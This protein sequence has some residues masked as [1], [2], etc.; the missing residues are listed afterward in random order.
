M[1]SDHH[2]DAAQVDPDNRLLW[3]MNRR[4]LT[5]ESIRDGMQAISGRLDYSRGGPSLG[6]D[7]PGNVGGIGGDVNPPTYTNKKT[8]DHVVNRRVVYLPLPRNRPTGQLEI[9][10]VFDFPHPNEIT[11]NRAEKTVATQALFLMNAPFV[12]DRAR[13]TAQRLLTPYLDDEKLDNVALV[14]QLYLIML[15]RPADQVEVREAVE[16][17]ELGQAAHNA[18][19]NPP[20]NSRL[21]AWTEL[22]HALFASNDFLFKE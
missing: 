8:P 22:C 1:S 14:Q 3:R 21:E 11:G 4:R 12:K 9:L 6:L 16:F 13:E 10:S 5:A 17:L 19:A 7:I 18:E 20:E 15:N 2:P